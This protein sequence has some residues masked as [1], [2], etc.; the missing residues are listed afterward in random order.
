M[1]PLTPIGE[2]KC[3]LSPHV[4]IVGLFVQFI[5]KNGPAC[6]DGRACQGREQG[7]VVAG[8]GLPGRDQSIQHA[9]TWDSP[10]VLNIGF[11][12]KLPIGRPLQKS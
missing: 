6:N 2:Q 4:F 3:N 8:K 11:D 9:R 1:L 7:P 10:D 12:P 5:P